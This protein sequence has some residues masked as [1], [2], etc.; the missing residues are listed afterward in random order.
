MNTSWNLNDLYTGFDS[1]EFLSDLKKCE[2]ITSKYK[3]LTSKLF[4]DHSNEI[5]T[6][7]NYL[8]AYIDDV[9]LLRKLQAFGHLTFTTNSKSQSALSLKA[10]VQKF[11]SELTSPTVAFKLWLKEVS[12]LDQ[13]A[14]QSSFIKEHFFYLDELIRSTDHMLSSEEEILVSK[15]VATGSSAWE[16]L[17]SKASSQL[18]YEVPLPEGKKNMPIMSI[19]NLAFSPDRKIRKIGYESELKAYEKHAEISAA[20]LNGIKGEVLTLSVLRGFSSPLEETLYNA[21]MSREILDAMISSMESHLDEFRRYLK[22]KSKLLG[23]DGPMPFYDV[24]APVSAT[25]R[26]YTIDEAQDFIVKYFADFSPELSHFADHC[27]NAN[28]IDFE[29]KEGKVGGAFC[30]NIPSI[31]Q[32]RVLLNFTGKLKNVLTIAHE[33]GHAFHGDRI[34]SESILNTTYPMPLAETASIFC[35]T[36]VRNAV[37]KDADEDL[38]LSILENS[39]Q[40]ATQV[41]VD[42]LSR[43]YFETSVFETRKDHPLSVNELKDL[44]I[45]A[46]KKSYGDG[47]DENYLHPFMWLNKTHYYYASRNFYNF[48]YAFGLLFATG[49]Y[50][51]YLEDKSGFVSKY[52][53]MLKATGKMNIQDVCALMDIDPSSQL[54]WNASLKKIKEDVDEFEKIVLKKVSTN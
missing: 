27:F 51:K 23:N 16:T 14:K 18:S 33:L 48:P 6:I 32:S 35:E 3:E 9:I 25:D 31:K 15:L 1:P 47:L 46:Q 44:M 21:R 52:D 36:I 12:S 38:K 50:A 22:L 10:K 17:Q 49:L 42:I 30:S 40:S 53:D 28:W 45:D 8:K 26:N 2:T 43:Y 37:L 54:F 29:P 20:A 41:V 4:C 7:E 34:M 39:L 19:R 24:F 13:L 5:E 11:N